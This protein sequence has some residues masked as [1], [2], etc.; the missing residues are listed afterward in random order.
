MG[1]TIGTKLHTLFFGSYVGADEFGNRYYQ[2]RK[3]S[4]W[5]R[6]RRWVIYNGK[7]E[8]SKVPPYWHGWLHYTL[9]APLSEQPKYLWQKKHQP[10]LT[11]TTGRY[12]PPGH[13]SK[14]GVRS[15]ASA[16]YEPWNPAE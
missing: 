9:N 14:G 1:A 11:G 10:N 6:K 12:L 15:A 5:N 2:A 13:I 7:P 3:T 8:A 16:D 4:H